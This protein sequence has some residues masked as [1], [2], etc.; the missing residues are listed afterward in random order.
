MDAKDLRTE[1]T[2]SERSSDGSKYAQ[3]GTSLQCNKNKSY[4]DIGSNP[5]AKVDTA[6]ARPCAVIG[7]DRVVP[8]SE[9]ND[10]YLKKAPVEPWPCPDNVYHRPPEYPHKTAAYLNPTRNISPRQTFQENMQRIMVPPTYNSVKVNEDAGFIQKVNVTSDAKYCEVPYS[11]NNTTNDP[12]NIRSVEMCL[13]NVNSGLGRPPH[14]WPP[15]GIN[16][17]PQRPYVSSDMY[18]FPE[19]PSCAGPRPVSV[20]RP[21]RTIP[22]ESGYIYPEHYYTEPNIRFKPY[23]NVKERYPQPRYDYVTNYSNPFHPSPCPPQKYELPKSLPLHPYSGYPHFKYID[24]RMPESMMEGYQRPIGQQ[25]SYNI[26][27]RNQMHPQY[28]PV[29]SNNSQSKIP[30]YPQDSALKAATSNKL[31]YDSNGKIYVEYD[32]TRAKPFPPSEGFYPNEISR[33]HAI[34]KVIGPNYPPINMHSVPPHSYYKKDNPQIKNYEY[35]NHYKNLNHTINLNSPTQRLITQ[36]SPNAIAIS[37]TD[38]NTSNDTLQTHAITHE[39]CAYV[40]QSSTTS[41]RSIDLGNSRIPNDYYTRYYDPRYGPIIRTAPPLSKTIRNNNNSS[42]DNKDKKDMDVR[43][44]LQM[45][46]EGDDDNPDNSSSKDIVVQNNSNE[47]NN[48]SKP[49]GVMNNQEQLY[50][51]GL[52]NVPSEELSKYEHIQKVSKLPENIKGYNSIELLNQFEE[53]I[54]SSNMHGFKMPVPK[55]FH[56]PTKQCAPKHSIGTLPRPISPLDVEAK[57]SQS[58][59]HKEVGCNFEIKPCSPKMLNVEIA[60]PVQNILNE[61]VIEKVTNPLSMISSPMLNGIDNIEHCKISDTRQDQLILEDSKEISSCNMINTQFSNP[62]TNSIKTNYSI[63]DLESNA[64]VCLASLPRLDNDIEL[65]FPEVNQQFINANKG[66]PVIKSHL[67]D[68]PEFSDLDETGKIIIDNKPENVGNNLVS[69]KVETEREFTKLSKYRKTKTNTSDARPDKLAVKAIRTDSVIIKNPE[70]LKVLENSKEQYIINKINQP[71]SDNLPLQEDFLADTIP[72]NNSVHE[73]KSIDVAPNSPEMAIDFRLPKIAGESFEISTN[74]VKN[75]EPVQF[76]KKEILNEGY[77]LYG[78]KEEVTKCTNLDKEGVLSKEINDLSS[79]DKR[80]ENETAFIAPALNIDSFVSSS[81]RICLDVANNVRKIDTPPDLLCAPEKITTC[82]DTIQKEVPRLQIKEENKALVETFI[83]SDKETLP[84]LQVKTSVSS[85]DAIKYENEAQEI[86]ACNELYGRCNVIKPTED[87]ISKSEELPESDTSVGESDITKNENNKDILQPESAVQVPQKVNEEDNSSRKYQE[88][89]DNT[90]ITVSEKPKQEEDLHDVMEICG[91]KQ[92]TDITKVSNFGE[93]FESINEKQNFTKEM[94]SN[95]EI[96]NEEDLENNK[97]DIQKGN[98]SVR[99]I[100][101]FYGYGSKELYS[102]WIQKLI[103]FDEG[104]CC[105]SLY[106]KESEVSVDIDTLEVVPKLLDIE[107]ESCSANL[108]DLI[109]SESTVCESISNSVNSNE[110][111]QSERV[112]EAETNTLL[113]PICVEKFH[114]KNTNDEMDNSENNPPRHI[115]NDESS[116]DIDEDTK[117]RIINKK[118]DENI[119]ANG[120]SKPGISEE[121]DQVGLELD[122]KEQSLNTH[123]ENNVAKGEKKNRIDSF[124]IKQITNNHSKSLK[125]SLS[126]SALDM[127]NT[128][129]SEREEISVVWPFKRRKIVHAENINDSE[130]IAQNLCN[131]LQHNRRNSISAVYNEDVSFCILIEDNTILTEDNDE[132][133]KICYTELSEDNLNEVNDTYTCEENNLEV[134]S[135]TISC[136]EEI[137]CEYP[138]N[139]TVNEDCDVAVGET[140]VEDIG[141]ME[142]VVS[143]DIAEDIVISTASTPTENDFWNNEESNSY[144]NCD[145]EHDALAGSL[146]YEDAV[147]YSDP[148][149]LKLCESSQI[150][151]NRSLLLRE[152]QNCEIF[153]GLYDNELLKILSESNSHSGSPCDNTECVI[154]SGPL[155]C[156]V[157]PDEAE[158]TNIDILSELSRKEN[159]VSVINDVE[160]NIKMEHSSSKTFEKKQDV[161]VHSCESSID[162][163]FS[164]KYKDNS[165][166]YAISSSPE[167]SSTTSEEKNSSLLLKITNYKGTKISQINSF[168]VNN[169]N[170]ISCKFTEKTDYV[171]PNDK[172]NSK[173]PLLTK[174]AQ[175]YIPPIKETIRD[176]K[177]KLSLPQ[178]SLLKLKQIKTSKDEPKFNKQSSVPS[179]LP[180]KPKPNF[181]DVLKSIDEIQIKMHKEK[182]K[183]V[184]KSIPKVVIKK[185]ENGSHYASTSNKDTFNP[186]LTGRKW[187]PWVFL[188]KNH[189][190]DKMAT[191]RKTRAIFSHRK[192]A[193]VLIEKFHK[194]KSA[195][196][197]KFIISQP[198]LSDS[199]TGQLKYTIRLKH[200]Y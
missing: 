123:V 38:S 8:P 190:I 56:A 32:N 128:K 138:E 92:K 59:I 95:H 133:D 78:N 118:N 81:E 189:F 90:I 194:Y 88:I 196:S 96:D 173:R 137:N 7:P 112:I 79:T 102:P 187:Q 84:E 64:G 37:P 135:E 17:R 89:A 6:G 111:L 152:H 18:Q 1:P 60:A 83:K 179:K 43:K 175:K 106:S 91:S 15:S 45:W 174:A 113:E 116:V 166:N 104:I 21:H 109:S 182:N 165:T 200:S 178:H 100:T 177:V 147:N 197:T 122:L 69:P 34:P 41:V 181:E 61:R 24:S 176:L 168:N 70:N 40:S 124:T 54:E 75:C 150:N 146:K 67:K 144:I 156:I 141:C 13:P 76:S 110:T 14:G 186:D 198:K 192:N 57:I 180:K 28:G 129:Q 188:E 125:R 130:I 4:Q 30:T 162:N 140:W 131:I 94:D 72:N 108:N 9:P 157:P 195:S 2:L 185:S 63:Q 65:N 155:E 50:V 73:T 19:Y 105:T 46:N 74:T 148:E 87:I 86:A 53:V 80:T 33:H 167:V 126:D 42:T 47:P 10:A 93:E 120:T 22:E 191:R 58:V 3:S 25:G 139:I 171:N 101:K 48:A 193:F 172:L 5:S 35:V 183:K 16:V 27:Y 163:V 119:C 153:N 12:K 184:K 31:P 36:F 23:P 164:Y 199:S 20:A 145:N 160:N 103:M 159:C 11:V 170:N 169:N 107:K 62:I 154:S 55:E 134:T 98:E 117:C 44:F 39:D 82:Q 99:D 142:T 85:P 149:I 66:E 97:N 127:I 71:Y 115:H 52:V 161:T 151:E 29:L 143:D 26:A 49:H 121:F 68:L 114:T 51:L 132:A 158:N 77:V 136:E